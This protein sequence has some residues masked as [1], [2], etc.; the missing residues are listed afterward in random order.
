MTTNLA[1]LILALCT[2]SCAADGCY[3]IDVG[4]L[5]GS[6]STGGGGAGAGTSTSAGTGG[7]TGSTSSTSTTTGAGGGGAPQAG[8]LL[9]AESFGDGNLQAANAVGVDAAGNIALAGVTWGATDFGG[10]LR[11]SLGGG[12][13]FAA[14]LTPSGGHTWSNLYGDNTGQEGT[15]IS[16][17]PS[18]EIAVAGRSSG[19]IDFGLG[20]HGN[21]GGNDAFVAKLASD[22]TALWSTTFGAGGEDGAFAVAID[23]VSGDVFA[24]GS[25]HGAPWFGQSQ[26]HA[27]G[28]D[29]ATFVARFAAADGHVMWAR[30][31]GDG[32]VQGL[33]ATATGVVACGTASGDVDF[34]GGP[35]S[36]KGGGS[37]F[38]A[39][40]TWAGSYGWAKMLTANSSTG[41][42]AVTT[43]GDV[44]FTGTHYGTVDLGGGPVDAS[45]MGNAFLSRYGDNGG[46]IVGRSFGEGVGL[47]VAATP[48]GHAV[49]AGYV[50]AMVTPTIDFGDGPVTPDAGG[51]LYVVRIDV[52]GKPAWSHVYPQAQGPLGIA[53][54]GAGN[55]ILVGG[56]F[57][58]LDLGKGAL[59]NAGAS[60]I[61]VA[62]WEP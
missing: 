32:V 54:D 13:A 55:T 7:A 4:G 8:G 40:L 28:A 46:Y 6:G 31:F 47:T 42:C 24:G 10:G 43:G 12:D 26:L 45:P 38:L 3:L 57:D 33:A 21:V 29:A 20:A 19:P 23:N 53:A 11:V 14:K 34:G 27:A 44:L 39:N 5:G 58:P 41:G 50:T 30:T 49:T 51:D 59:K 62:K 61:F 52:A 35:M 16:V 22:G 1:A 9:W 17:S 18:G 2:A 48:D 60:D 25:F 36:P 56:F 37:A 15:A